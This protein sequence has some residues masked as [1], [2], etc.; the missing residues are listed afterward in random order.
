MQLQRGDH[1]K[2]GPTYLTVLPVSPCGRYAVV[3]WAKGTRIVEGRIV[4]K[5]LRKGRYNVTQHVRRCY[6]DV[7]VIE[8]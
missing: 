3:A 4:V 7:L 1:L 8:S 6:Q 2:R 5:G